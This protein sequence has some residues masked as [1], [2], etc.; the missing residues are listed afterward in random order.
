[1]EAADPSILGLSYD[2]L[3]SSCV[4]NNAQYP[5]KSQE[6]GLSLFVEALTTGQRKGR[7]EKITLLV[8]HEIEILCLLRS[9]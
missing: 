1:M 4:H 3:A 5:L 6:E 9:E 2:P 8:F 7:N